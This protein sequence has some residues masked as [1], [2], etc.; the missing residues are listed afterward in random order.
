MCIR[1]RLVPMV[2]RLIGNAVHKYWRSRK[3][4]G[5]DHLGNSYYIYQEAPDEPWRRAIKPASKIDV[6]DFQDNP[7]PIE[8]EMW[9]HW[10]REHAPTQKEVDARMEFDGVLADRVKVVEERDRLMQRQEREARGIQPSEGIEEGSKH[11]KDA[12]ADAPRPKFES[13]KPS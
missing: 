3:T 13:W 5:I 8:W 9:L 2:L 6:E 12:N 4:M 7:V 10:Q 11:F 1:D